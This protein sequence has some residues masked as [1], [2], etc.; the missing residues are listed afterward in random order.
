[1]PYNSDSKIL[2]GTVSANDIVNLINDEIPKFLD[3]RITYW[4]DKTPNYWP[5]G[6]KS[7]LSST[8]TLPPMST[9]ENMKGTSTDYTNFLAYLDQMFRIWSM[10]RNIH[11]VYVRNNG[12]TNGGKAQTSLEGG[13]AKAFLTENSYAISGRDKGYEMKGKALQNDV[14]KQFLGKLRDDINNAPTLEYVYADPCHHNCHGS[15]HGQC[16]GSC[17]ISNCSD[18]R[19][20]CCVSNCADCGCITNCGAHCNNCSNCHDDCCHGSGGWR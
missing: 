3:E 20:N 16:H 15:C 2:N 4:R 14:I 9:P 13:R 10:A 17:C 5:V 6:W 8:K 19:G 1:M 7:K 12:Y 11:Y 18:C